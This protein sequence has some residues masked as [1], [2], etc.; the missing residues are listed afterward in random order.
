MRVANL[1]SRLT[2]IARRSARSTSERASDG[3]FGSDPQAIYERW[4]EF[5]AVGAARRRASRSTPPASGRP[6]RARGRCSRSAST[7]RCTRSEAGLE[8]PPMPLTFTKFPRCIVGPDATV[9]RRDRARRLGG[10]A[11]RGDRAPRPPRRA[12]GWA[13]V[14]GAHRRPGPLGARRADARLAAAVQPR[15]VVPRASGRPARGSSRRTR[16]RPRR[17]GDR[18][19]GQRRD[20]AGRPHVVDALLRRARSSRGCR[21]IC[22][23]LPGDLIFTGTPAGVG[24]RMDPPRYLQPGDE[25]VCTIEGIGSITT[26]FVVNDDGSGGGARRGR[27]RGRRVRLG[28]HAGVRGGGRATSR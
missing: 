6:C 16:E 4:D 5:A 24:N 7:T 23:L 11:R 15:Q 27:R 22:P 9:G 8:L 10:R 20:D 19:R 14:A 25:L 28:D 21:A 17:P 26:R 1:D 12:D 13:H 18:L 3:R 2:L